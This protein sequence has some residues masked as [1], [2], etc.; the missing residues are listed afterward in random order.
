MALLIS[1]TSFAIREVVL[2]D[3]P[4]ALVA[5]SAKATV[6]VL[7]LP[8]G[9]VIDESIDIMRWALGQNDEEYWL[10]GN[11]AALIWRFDTKFKDHLD[12]YKY[13]ERH[14]ADPIEHRDAGLALLHELEERLSARTNLCGSG[15][16]LSD[17]AIMPFVRQYASVDRNWF[18]NQRIPSTQD[19]LT[20]HLASP[21]FARAMVR[22]APWV[23]EDAPIIWSGV[24]A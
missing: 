18:D 5:A 10:A 23:P 19:W 24:T 21:L 8:D 15:R 1:G 3:K 13:A 20:R 14:N 12:R 7:C 4:A 22:L 6:P 9:V 16:T 2:R 17:I 11:D